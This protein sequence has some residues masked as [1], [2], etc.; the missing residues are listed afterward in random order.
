MVFKVLTLTSPKKCLRYFNFDFSPNVCSSR[1]KNPY[2]C[3]GRSLRIPRGRGVLKVNF[4]EA[5]YK[6][7]L[8]FPGGRV[9]AK[10]KT[11]LVGGVRIFS[12]TA[13][14]PVIIHRVY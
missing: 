14:F 6:N 1:K 12:G 3:Y 9:G 2:P 5:M 13:Q 10:P 4:S 11:F 7:E 8:E